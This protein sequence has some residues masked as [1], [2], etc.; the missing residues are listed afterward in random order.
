MPDNSN[1]MGSP[2]S[3]DVI[4]QIKEL[5][6]RHR[7]ES[8]LVTML[9]YINTLEYHK[10]LA[11]VSYGSTE[12]D[13]Y[14]QVYDSFTA[15]LATAEDYLTHYDYI[16]ATAADDDEMHATLGRY[17]N[18]LRELLEKLE[19]L[20]HHF[21]E[22][23]P[24][25]VTL[26]LVSYWARAP[27]KQGK[28]AEIADTSNRTRLRR[29]IIGLAVIAALVIA[30]IVWAI[31]S[32]M[33]APLTSSQQ[34]DDTPSSAV[35]VE[36]TQETDTGSTTTT[37]TITDAYYEIE[38]VQ[39]KLPEYDGLSLTLPEWYYRFCQDMVTGPEDEIDLGPDSFHVTLGKTTLQEFVDAGFTVDYTTDVVATESTRGDYAYESQDS[40]NFYFNYEADT[41]GNETA[42]GITDINTDTFTYDALKDKAGY[43]AADGYG[44][45]TITRDTSDF[46]QVQYHTFETFENME[47]D[48]SKCY[49]YSV[50]LRYHP[51]ASQIS[52]SYNGLTEQSSFDDFLAAFPEPVAS[53]KNSDADRDGNITRHDIDMDITTETNLRLVEYYKPDHERGDMLLLTISNTR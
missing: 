10:R 3:R 44:S 5:D 34:E 46:I 38:P 40:E 20:D 47:L 53:S 25:K 13:S 26:Q 18:E 2:L 39:Q 31:I 12:A 1:V 24:S 35:T 15:N 4:A 11:K 28:T 8:E 27:Y 42:L 6:N 36:E 23:S 21:H 45:A 51:S 33:T 14:A 22:I 49:V 52:F 37:Q 41:Q 32:R 50:V 19:Q 43:V 30:I 17:L 16:S 7:F 48:L 29:L 9:S